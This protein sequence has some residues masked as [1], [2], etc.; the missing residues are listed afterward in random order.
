M[1][2][3]QLEQLLT[4]LTPQQAAN[5]E[6]GGRFTLFSVVAVNPDPDNDSRV[7]LAGITL[8]SRENMIEVQTEAVNRSRVFSIPSLVE[9]YDIDPRPELAGDDLLGQRTISTR[10]TLG[11]SVDWRNV[12]GYTIRHRVTG[13]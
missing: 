6:G 9:L 7:Q 4:E 10:S 2:N 1:K 13:T 5:L 11:F 12:N 3:Q 8:F